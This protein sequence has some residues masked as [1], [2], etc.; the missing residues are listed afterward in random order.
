MVVFSN[1]IS[2]ILPDQEGF[3]QG[4]SVVPWTQGLV[5][6][7]FLA[8]ISLMLFEPSICCWSLMQLLRLLLIDLTLPSNLSQQALLI[9]WLQPQILQLVWNKEQYLLIEHHPHETETESSKCF[10]LPQINIGEISTFLT[11]AWKLR[12]KFFI[13]GQEYIMFEADC[14]LICGC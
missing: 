1:F 4:L 13:F 11:V 10:K 12:F 2:I 9:F 14:L 7:V 3:A 8:A 5:W 6:Q